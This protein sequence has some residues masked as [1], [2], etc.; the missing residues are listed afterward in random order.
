MAAESHDR[1]SPR[2]A[3]V[4]LPLRERGARVHFPSSLAPAPRFADGACVEQA[5]ELADRRVVAKVEPGTQDQPE[6][7]R[8]LGHLNGIRLAERDRLLDEHML[9][10]AQRQKRLWGMEAIRGGHIDGVEAPSSSIFSK[11]S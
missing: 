5:L 7:V 4:V 8:G 1:S 2:H 6:P 3:R 11:L 9:A 10:G